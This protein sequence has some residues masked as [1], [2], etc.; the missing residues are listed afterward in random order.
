MQLACEE[1]KM[2]KKYDVTNLSL[3][4]EGRDRILWADRD[5]PVLAKIR[6]EFGHARAFVQKVEELIRAA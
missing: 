3:A 2:A 4:K 5:M 1:M 6:E